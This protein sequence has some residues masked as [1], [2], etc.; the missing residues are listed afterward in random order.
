[1]E[2]LEI[3]N[4]SSFLLGM[5]IC[6]IGG[7]I[8][9]FSPCSISSISIIIGYLSQNKEKKNSFKYS[10]L[11]ALGTVIA[12]VILGIIS[13]AIGNRVV[14]LQKNASLVLAILL[15]GVSLIL[16]GVFDKEKTSCKIPHRSKNLF[17]AFLLGIM[18]AL[19][20]SPCTA[21]ILI[22]ILSY[23]GLSGNLVAGI[24][25]MISYSIGSIVIILIA[26]LS[27]SC[28]QKLSIN[29]NFN[30]IG[31]IFKILLG[32]IAL[33]IGLYYLYLWA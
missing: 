15:I 21:P 4:N 14:F 28:I 10:V 17:T 20:S 23:A 2:S 13:V 27:A 11:F 26:G 16:F 18:G 30:K 31:K 25:Y 22:A 33:A 29:E 32:I 19:I 24:F 7:F 8:A 5:I 3:L 6:F 9:S 12:F 1:M